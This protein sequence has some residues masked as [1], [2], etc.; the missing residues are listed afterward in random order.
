MRSKKNRQHDGFPFIKSN[1]TY[2]PDVYEDVST[3]SANLKKHYFDY[4]DFSNPLLLS[5]DFFK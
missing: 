1:R 4:M 2:I 3:Y 5:S